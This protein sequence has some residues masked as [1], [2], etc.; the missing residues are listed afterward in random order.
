MF[1]IKRLAKYSTLFLTYGTIY[2]II[3]CIYKGKLSDWR[4]FV[5]AGFIGVV[6]GL[7][8]NLFEMN[9]D[10]VLQCIVG[11]LIASLSEAIG[12]FYWNLQCGLRI[13]DYS[14]L[15]FSF[16]GGQ[17]NLFFSIAWMF[18]SGIVIVLDD[19]LRWK[20]YNEEKPKYYIHGNR[21]F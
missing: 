18:L 15:P 5:L 1:T 10:F 12:G 2:F 7:I 13:W 17:I 14:A 8:N 21:I 20:L 19:F 4:M 6:I 9:T 3:E 16:V 11:A